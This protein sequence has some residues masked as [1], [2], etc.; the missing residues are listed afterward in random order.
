MQLN[1]FNNVYIPSNFLSN[2]YIDV[3]LECP[4]QTTTAIDYI[5][6]NPLRNFYIHLVIVDEI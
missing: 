2:G 1:F 3:E 4:A 5:T 6:G